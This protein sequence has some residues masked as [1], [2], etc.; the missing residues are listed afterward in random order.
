MWLFRGLNELIYGKP[1]NSACYMV[2]MVYVL[3]IIM[4]KSQVMQDP[5]GEEKP[6]PILLLLMLRC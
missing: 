3:H 4:V 6:L 1:W 5:M 2:S